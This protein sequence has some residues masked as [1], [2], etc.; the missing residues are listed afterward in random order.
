[1]DAQGQGYLG[2]LT[3]QIQNVRLVRRDS[4]NV[5]NP[6]IVQGGSS[7]DNSTIAANWPVVKVINATGGFSTQ[8]SIFAYSQL[9]KAPS[10]TQALTS[11]TKVG[12]DSVNV[13]YVA[14]DPD[15]NAQLLFLVGQHLMLQQEN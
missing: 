7:Y 5:N 3:D 2:Y 4:G 10:F 8:G 11:I 14:T 15:L 12:G 1:M 6:W 13:T 9:N